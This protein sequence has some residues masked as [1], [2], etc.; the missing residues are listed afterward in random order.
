MIPCSSEDICGECWC[1]AKLFHMHHEQM[2]HLKCCL[3][4]ET[5]HD[6]SDNSSN[7]DDNTHIDDFVLPHKVERAMKELQ[8]HDMELGKEIAQVSEHVMQYT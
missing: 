4:V 8:L 6:S 7:E 3:D 5:I 1:F 2:E